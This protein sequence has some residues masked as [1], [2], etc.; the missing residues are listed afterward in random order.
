MCCTALLKKPLDIRGSKRDNCPSAPKGRNFTNPLKI[1]SFMSTPHAAPPT[2]KSGRQDLTEGPVRNHL[3]RLSLPM[4]WGIMIIISFQLVDT[5]FVSRLGTEELAALSFTFPVTFL[6]FSFIIGF[7]IAMSSVL[8]RLIGER[9]EELLHRIATHGLMLVF[10]IS[11]AI[12]AAGYIFLD[13]IFRLL[14]ANE[15]MLPL[16]REYMTPWFAG[17]VFIS[18]PMIGNAAI[19]AAGDS[20]MPAV[21]MTIA[22]LINV[23]LDPLMIFGLAGFP[24]MGL[25]GAACAT[26]F[27][28]A[29]AMVA[30]LYIIHVRKKLTDLSYIYRL[31]QFG[32]SAKR[33]LFIALPVGITNALQPAVN[34]IIVSLLA[35]SGH[36]AVAAFGIVTRIE[37]FAFVILMGLAVSMGPIVGQNFGARKFERIN[38]AIRIAIRF[39]VLWSL[40]V[41]VILGLLAKPIAGLF[42]D[43]PDVIKYAALFFWIVPLSYA[44][45]NLIRGWASAFNAMGMPQRSFIMVV[46]EMLAM[47]IPA[48]YIG[49]YLA[50]VPGLFAAIAC[51][52]VVAGLGFHFWSRHKCMEMEKVAQ[53]DALEPSAA[54]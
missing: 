44:C 7:S 43:E 19:R 25:E 51:V 6:I 27:A 1:K 32:N 20:R 3:I 10:L 4:T 45:A 23:V 18:L 9:N 2:G 12:A 31:K 30:G 46:A 50:G 22:A 39:S 28:N 16:I 42:S 49:H 37:A 33:L 52:N 11:M 48:V 34:A 54:R 41:A 13:P 15:T 14:G 29:C 24:K 21:I 8:S 38:E 53:L 40:A 35:T 36:A 17:A 47:M 26:V 5:F